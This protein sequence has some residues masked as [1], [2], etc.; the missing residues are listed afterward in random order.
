MRF[1][2]AGIPI[3]DC[4]LEH[5]S[6]V[7][8]AGLLR[9][10]HVQIKAVAVGAVAE[11]LSSQTLGVQARFEGFLGSSVWV[12]SGTGSAKP[13]VFHIQSFQLNIY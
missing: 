6:E 3:V 1:N 12:K 9:T 4:L 11:Q 13:V 7:V 8:E 2:P 10:V 5:Q